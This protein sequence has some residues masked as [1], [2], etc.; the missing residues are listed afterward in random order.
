MTKLPTTLRVSMGRTER[1]VGHQRNKRLGFPFLA[2]ITTALLLGARA[3]ESAAVSTML[4]TGAFFGAWLA[5]MLLVDLRWTQPKTVNVVAH[6]EGVVFAP[7]SAAL[8]A[9]SLVGGLAAL[10]LARLWSVPEQWTHLSLYPRGIVLFGPLMGLYLIAEAL[11]RLRRP[12]GLTLDER[13]LS[14]VRAGPRFDVVWASLANGSAAEGKKSRH[15]ILA[16]ADGRDMVAIPQS[17]VGGDVYA[18]ATVI[19]YYLHHPEERG[20]LS[21]GLDAVRHVDAEVSAGRFDGT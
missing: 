9:I 14:G 1:S 21:D 7:P 13:G 6:A 16:S 17:T 8:L 5:V 20:R 11:W 3:D 12:A 18:V 4:V 15:L 2:V 10:S 19:N